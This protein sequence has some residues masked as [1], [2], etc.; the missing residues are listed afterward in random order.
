MSTTPVE[1]TAGGLL[2]LVRAGEAS[3][4]ADLGRLTG[5]SRTAV[6]QRVTALVAAG[7]VTEGTGLASTGGRPA[8]S[9]SFNVD[10][11]V[12]VG[13]AVGR[14]RTQVGVFDLDG[15]EIVG[16]TRDHEV[17]SGPDEVM[18]DVAERLRTLLDGIE[19]PVL[20]IGLSLPGTVDPE[21]RVSVDAPVMKGWDG[22]PL[23]PYLH[24][25]CAAPLH[26]TN[27]TSAL[28]RSEL[29]GP[30]PL[31][32][33][34]LVV[35][36]STGLGLGVIADGRLVN[37]SR[38]VT[39]ELGHTRVEGADELLCR[40]GAHGCLETVAA[41]WAMVNR[42]VE[43][44]TEA[45]HVRDLVALALDG[46]PVAR[47]MLRESGRRVG[48]V[49]AVAVNLLHPQTVV[50]GGDM[51]SAFDLYTAGMRE[52]VYARAAGSVT[53][54]LRFAPA[55][56]GDSAGLVGCAALV[57]DHELSPAAVDARLRA[58]RTAQP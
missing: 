17:G 38:G 52:S 16:D 13:A 29:F 42:L 57:I 18:V 22:V 58:S 56:H 8:G 14:S 21:R 36:A 41:G 25:A 34:V 53:R 54:D 19:P 26:L 23:A 3:T 20:G 24:D 47:S 51:G 30:A 10:A 48:E 32:S 4:R 12:V 39:G 31:G 27:D 40:C 6:S 50:V 44:G 11:A 7:L 1:T 2:S 55:A 28:T 45:R 15:R 43:G 5:L 46:D 9:L 33:D 49:L 35:K 37:G